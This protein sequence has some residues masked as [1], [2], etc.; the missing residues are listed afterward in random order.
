[1]EAAAH[2]RRVAE[3]V[4]IGQNADAI[5]DDHRPRLRMLELRQP[6]GAG[7]LQVAQALGDPREVIGIRLVRREQ[8]PRRRQLVQQ[9][10]ERR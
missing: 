5:D 8:Q 3:G 10:R 9:I 2:V 1:M 7:Q 6:D 4:E